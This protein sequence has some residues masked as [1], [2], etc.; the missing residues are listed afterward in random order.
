MILPRVLS[1]LE[2]YKFPGSGWNGNGNNALCDCEQTEIGKFKH[3]TLR[4][5]PRN[6]VALEI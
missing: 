4:F 6:R 1:K 3:G 2:K 5:E